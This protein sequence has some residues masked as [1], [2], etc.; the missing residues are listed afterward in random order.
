[1]TIELTADD[2]EVKQLCIEPLFKSADDALRFAY[3]FSAQQYDRPL[4]NRMA[5]KTSRSGKGL[6]GLDGSGQAGM[7]RREMAALGPFYEA[8][9]IANYAPRDIPCECRAP[10][11]SGAK[12]N[13]EWSAAIDIVT[14]EAM[15]HLTG[16]LS[17]YKL[18]RSIVERQF[19]VKHKIGDM[20]DECGVD[21]DTAS[22]HNMILTMWLTGDKKRDV[23]NRK[24]GEIFRAITAASEA[25]WQ[26]G[27]IG[28]IN[29]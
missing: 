26:A 25:L 27:F 17:H 15:Q 7:I 29:R 3:H 11:C 5:D 20:A 6:A 24:I 1:M 23:P 12:V 14:T 8:I 28:A 21:R 13:K 22:A 18:R 19:G 9:V 10:C 4:M 2:N 16:K